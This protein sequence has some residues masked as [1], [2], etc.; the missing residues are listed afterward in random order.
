MVKGVNPE[1]NSYYNSGI[2]YLFSDD[3]QEPNVTSATTATTN[4]WSTGSGV[5]NPYTLGKKF[6]FN[7]T[8]DEIN[9]YYVDKPVGAV[10]LLG[11]VVTIFNQDLVDAF[12][13]T[14]G[15]GG[16]GTTL[17]TFA[18][19]AASTTFKSVDVDQSLNMTL[20]AGKNEFTTSNNPTW[21]STTCDGK[22]YVTY[23]DF[24]D[25]Q[26]N[27]VAKGVTDSPLTKEKNEQLIIEANI[28]F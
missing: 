21:N 22:I 27:L 3:I 4:S 2:V 1:S 24:Y 6:P 16:T 25:E 20:I 28:K 5:D 14:V 13:F 19:S 10:D 18:S 8:T 26:G 11:G 23:I 9:G 17:V 7:F 15:T 12:D